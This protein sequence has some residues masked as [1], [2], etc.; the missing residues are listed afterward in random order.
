MKNTNRLGTT[1]IVIGIF[2]LFRK[3]KIHWGIGGMYD[4]SWGILFSSILVMAIGLFC[5]KIKNLKRHI[6]S[7]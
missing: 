1:F 4:N 7:K 3:V 2:I 5:I 6:V